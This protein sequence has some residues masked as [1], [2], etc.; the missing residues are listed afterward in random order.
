M[1]VCLHFR[2]VDLQGAVEKLAQPK[3]TFEALYNHFLQ[4]ADSV[5]EPHSSSR[6]TSGHSLSCAFVEGNAEEDRLLCVRAM[7]ALYNYHAAA[8]GT[9]KEKSKS[10]SKGM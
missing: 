3:E 6:I 4:L 10:S 7:A 8:I 9:L 1:L 2:K 5:A